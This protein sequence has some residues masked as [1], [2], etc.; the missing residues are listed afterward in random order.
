MTKKHAVSRHFII[1]RF[2]VRNYMSFTSF[3]V[4]L[5]AGLFAMG[6]AWYAYNYTP[7][8]TARGILQNQPYNS[9]NQTV[10]ESDK[11]RQIS[12]VN[13]VREIDLMGTTTLLVNVSN[14][15]FLNLKIE[16]VDDSWLSMLHHSKER[17][18][19]V[20]ARMHHDQSVANSQSG[21]ELD[22][23]HAAIPEQLIGDLIYIRYLGEGKVALG[24]PEQKIVYGKLNSKIYIDSED[25]YLDFDWPGARKGDLVKITV[26]DPHVAAEDLQ[27]KL[28][29][30]IPQYSKKHKLYKDLSDQSLIEVSYTDLS[31]ALAKSIVNSVLDNAVLQ[32][33]LRKQEESHHALDFLAEQKHIVDDEINGISKEITHIRSTRQPLA[34]DQEGLFFVDQIKALEQNITLVE[35]KEVEMRT[36]MTDANPNLQAVR[37]QL[38]SLHDKRLELEYKMRVKPSVQMTVNK[39]E[40]ELRADNEVDKLLEMRIQKLKAMSQAAIGDLQIVEKAYTPV[41]SVSYEPWLIVF[42]ST[43]L[44]AILGYI[45]AL[46]VF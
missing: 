35:Q 46:A 36:R 10:A 17:L 19:R 29:I 18:Q 38:A 11:N 13:V 41:T 16:K 1:H 33:K 2:S 32:S 9:V 3:F 6:G 42:L 15:L 12:P 40:E 44:G 7:Q 25:A 23:H 22:I 14:D 4:L 5:F 21:R 26:M 28:K 24:T 8:F 30:S 27:E 34:N 45:V 43:I 39:L 20:Y 31:P 37:H